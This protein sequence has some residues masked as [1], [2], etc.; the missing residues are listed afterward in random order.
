[1]K[2]EYKK[3]GSTDLLMLL[4][5]IFWSVNFPLIKIALLEFTPL[6]F[7]GIRLAF[8]SVVLLLVLVFSGEGFSF[9]GDEKKKLLVMGLSGNTCYQLLFIQGLDLTTASNTAIIIALAPVFITALSSLFKHERLNWAA[10]L[11]ILV[12]FIGFFFVIS[13]QPGSFSFSWRSLGGDVMILLG[14]LFWAVY[15]VLSK[16][17][18]ENHSPLKVT[19]VSMAIGTFFYLPF[20]LKPMIDL[21]YQKISPEAWAALFYSG[22]FAL[23]ISYVIWYASVKKVGNSRTAIYDNFVP[24]LTALFAYLFIGERISIFQVS[25]MLIIFLGV[26]LTRSGYRFLG[27]KISLIPSRKNIQ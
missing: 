20:C 3:L 23:V 21:P 19:S 15:T 7:N 26:Y 22:L 14:N 24:V 4:A 6:G 9:S 2:E 13:K 12:S 27:R 18:L 17:L 11:G 25:G 1:M 8:A 5:I 16:P 10:W